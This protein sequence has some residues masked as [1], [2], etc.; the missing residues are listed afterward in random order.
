MSGDGCGTDCFAELGY[1]CEGEP[2]ICTS[3]ICASCDGKVSKLTLKY[4]GSGNQVNIKVK[5][6]KGDIVF[7]DLIDSGE[8]F[9]FVG[10][11]NGT[12][13]P[14]ITILENDVET[15]T[16][17]TSCSQ[18]IGPGLVVGD[19]EVVNGESKNNGL[20]CGI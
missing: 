1:V 3:Q 8:K 13:S 11:E 4:N 5:Q 12:M 6:K 10:T 19:F 20:L 2:S 15:T 16:I 7:D 18:A 17:H 9:F 14:D